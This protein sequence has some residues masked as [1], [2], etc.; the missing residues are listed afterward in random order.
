ML[1]FVEHLTIVIYTTDKLAR[2]VIY[3]KDKLA[4]IVVV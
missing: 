4:R 1:K 2:I 3:I